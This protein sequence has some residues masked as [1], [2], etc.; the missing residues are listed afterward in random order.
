M[1]MNNKANP[2]VFMRVLPDGGG[3][4]VVVNPANVLWAVPDGPG[5]TEI[6]MLDGPAVVVREDFW[7]VAMWMYVA[8]TR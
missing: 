2:D 5:T 6:R 1:A 8:R 3:V 7:D 4:D